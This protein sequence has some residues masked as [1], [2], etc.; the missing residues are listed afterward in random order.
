MHLVSSNFDQGKDTLAHPVKDD[1]SRIRKYVTK[2]NEVGT[3]STNAKTRST[4]L[5]AA[6]AKRVVSHQMSSNKKQRK[7]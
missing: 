3:P 5:D 4:V 1:I 2:I 6:A 7:K